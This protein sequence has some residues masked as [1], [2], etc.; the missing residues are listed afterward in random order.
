[1]TPPE[2]MDSFGVCQLG[3]RFELS[4][5]DI[6]HANFLFDLRGNLRKIR[7][8][9]KNPRCDSKDLLFCLGSGVSQYPHLSGYYVYSGKKDRKAFWTSV[10]KF[11]NHHNFLWWNRKD[12]G[13]V[14]E[15]ANKGVMVK[16]QSNNIL[17]PT[18]GWRAYDVVK[19]EV[20]W[21]HECK[22]TKVSC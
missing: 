20:V 14:I 2:G 9:E 5:F 12:K 13:Y 16:T 7:E 3:Q 19:G 21:C 6:Q 17:S 15:H 10:Q 11:Q 1:M 18:H 4:E 22:V 8:V